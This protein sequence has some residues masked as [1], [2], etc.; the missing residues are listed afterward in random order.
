MLEKD[1]VLLITALVEA[2]TR[3]LGRPNPAASVAR[4][5]AVD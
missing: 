1:E 4:A 5:A 2:R 3:S